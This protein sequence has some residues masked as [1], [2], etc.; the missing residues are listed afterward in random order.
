[1]NFLLLII[2]SFSFEILSISYTLISS[3]ISVSFE[4][5]LKFFVI[6]V[7]VFIRDF[8]I[9]LDVLVEI[10]VRLDHPLDLKAF[11]GVL[12][13]ESAEQ[14]EAGSVL[15]G[16]LVF[17]GLLLLAFGLAQLANVVGVV[18][19]F[20]ELVRTLAEEEVSAEHSIHN[21]AEREHVAKLVVVVLDNGFL[22][23][24]ERQLPLHL[25]RRELHGGAH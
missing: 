15:L 9:V 19:L 21:H 3:F 20:G 5:T 25:F 1:L 14:L 12:F 7:Q 4:T 10:R 8:E 17:L 18:A 13:K 16:E 6:K 2:F 11:R 22:V 24:L 23:L